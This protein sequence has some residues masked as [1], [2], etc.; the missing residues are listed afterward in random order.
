SRSG[1]CLWRCLYPSRSRDGH[2]GPAD[3]TTIAM[4]ER[5]CGEAIGSIRR[6][7]LD[8][9]VV[10][11]ERHLCHLLGSYQKYYIAA[12]GL[13]AE[14]L[15]AGKAASSRRQPGAALA[16]RALQGLFASDPEMVESRIRKGGRVARSNRGARPASDKSGR[17]RDTGITCQ[18]PAGWLRGRNRIPRG[19]ASC[20]ISILPTVSGVTRPTSRPAASTTATAGADFS[21]SSRNAS[22]RC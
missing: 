5:T 19:K 8:H 17:L 14:V 16:R 22:S 2:S 20:S 10:F 6:D 21:C 18:A 4:A 1:L 11:G 3:R 15:P 7:C 13:G 12:N 9:V